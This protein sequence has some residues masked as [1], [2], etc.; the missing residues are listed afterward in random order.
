M[1]IEPGIVR[2]NFNFSDP[3]QNKSVGFILCKRIELPC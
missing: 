1:F 2:I 3:M